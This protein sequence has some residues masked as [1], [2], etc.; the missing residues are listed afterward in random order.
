[1]AVEQIGRLVSPGP[2][3]LVAQFVLAA[4]F[5]SAGL[6][7][8]SSFSVF[9]RTVRGLGFGENA[10]YRLGILLI[11]VEIVTSIALVIA[12]S[13]VVPRIFA[14]GLAVFFALAG[15]F[16]LVTDRDVP[17]NCIGS[18]GQGTLGWR[19]LVLLPIWLVLVVAAQLGNTTWLPDVGLAGLSLVVIL[20]IAQKMVRMRGLFRTLR[21]DRLALDVH[22]AAA[23]TRGFSAVRMEGKS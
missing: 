6:A 5:I 11:C 14:L 9:R 15:T 21:G 2:L 16:A 12:P 18:L 8:A 20:L 1:M 17:C 13:Q 10:S 22:L 19:Q 23:T 7:K 3:G 4:V